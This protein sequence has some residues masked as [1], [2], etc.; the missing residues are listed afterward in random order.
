VWV[1]FVNK[2]LLVIFRE[3]IEERGVL[4]IYCGHPNINLVN[5]APP[6]GKGGIKIALYIMSESGALYQPDTSTPLQ[7]DTF[8]ESFRLGTFARTYIFL[9]FR[10]ENLF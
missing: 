10:F 5:T 1:H 3:Y 2:I 6:S 7:I 8:L 9:G 4:N